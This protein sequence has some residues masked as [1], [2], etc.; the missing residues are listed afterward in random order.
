MGGGV[1]KKHFVN[2]IEL[3]EKVVNCLINIVLVIF[4]FANITCNGK[5]YFKS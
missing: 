4:N 5:S 1:I 2:L 3:F